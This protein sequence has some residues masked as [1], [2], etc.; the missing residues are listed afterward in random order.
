MRCPKCRK[1]LEPDTIICPNCKKL[2]VNDDAVQARA[3]HKPVRIKD[4]GSSGDSLYAHVLKPRSSISVK[5]L[6]SRMT[7]SSYVKANQHKISPSDE[8]ESSQRIRCKNCRTE[9]VKSDRFCKK[10]GTRI[11]S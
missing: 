9:N 3:G 4:D 10:C 6:G 5:G 8:S 11:T 7:G 1:T 2:L